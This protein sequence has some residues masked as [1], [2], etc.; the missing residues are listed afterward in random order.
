[1]SVQPALPQPCKEC[2]WRQANQRQRHPHGFYTMKNLRRLWAGLRRGVRMTCHPTDPRMV[3]YEGYEKTAEVS[4]THEC[5]GALILVQ[6]EVMRFQG[7]CE[8]RQR[9]SFKRY[10]LKSP[11]GM[12]R[13][14]LAEVVQRYLFGGTPFDS[15]KMAQPD[16]NMEGIGHPDLPDWEKL[17]AS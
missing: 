1:M 17:D 8:A 11:K 7:C 5:M 4:S 3:D 6:R 2:P 12:T 15:L 10:R 14:G 9:D 16:L 13:V